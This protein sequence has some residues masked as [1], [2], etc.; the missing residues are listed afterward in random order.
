M[1]KHQLIKSKFSKN[2]L[3]LHFSENHF[4]TSKK[5]VFLSFINLL[6]K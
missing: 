4:K 2:L 1:I 3:I 5:L 6:Q